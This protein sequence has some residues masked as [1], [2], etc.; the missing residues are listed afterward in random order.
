MVVPQ[1]LATPRAV[2]RYCSQPAARN[3]RR[4]EVPVP[5]R[6]KGRLGGSPASLR[7]RGPTHGPLP[8]RATSENGTSVKSKESVSEHAGLGTPTAGHGKAAPEGRGLPESSGHGGE[9]GS[10]GEREGKGEAEDST[11][12]AV[13]QGSAV[14]GFLLVT[15]IVGV[16]TLGVLY[17]DEINH[18][19]DFFSTYIEGRPLCPAYLTLT[20]RGWGTFQG[21]L[22]AWKSIQLFM[23]AVYASCLRQRLIPAVHSRCSCRLFMPAVHPCSS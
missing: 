11:G 9:E 17:K 13:G 3:Q 1:S 12:L 8:A 4:T 10:S 2:D 20:V 22:C 23:P 5:V 15:A 18:A 16:G 19:I 14:L 6:R 21:V 7:Q